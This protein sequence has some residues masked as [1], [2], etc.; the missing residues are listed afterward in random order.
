MQSAAEHLKKSGHPGQ[1]LFL[2]ALFNVV[3]AFA[4]TF[5]YKIRVKS[6][7]GIPAEGP[8][9]IL[10]K[11]WSLADVPL[12]KLAVTRDSG[13]H[14]WCVMKASLASGPFGGLMLK[15]GG[16]PINRDN[17]EKSK[18]DL[19]LARHVLHDG[20]MLCVFPEQ[21]TVPKKM[22]RG[23]SP[24]FR[25]IMGRPER[26]IGVV[27]IGFH[28]TKRRFRRTLV[29]IHIGEA[30]Y[31]TKHDD[32]ETFLHERMR[33]IARLSRL[34]YGFAPPLSRKERRAAGD[35]TAQNENAPA[36]ADA[37]ADALA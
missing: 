24:G 28:Y 17:P 20:A 16:I 12:G 26:P 9:I 13:R 22:G 31:F 8:V 4:Y 25:F 15:V 14:L 2:S 30:T 19:L 32:A 37:E 21:T 34:E 7:K 18:N 27:C 29:D 33:D 11:H 36:P 35:A 1:S 5:I 6:A 23:R 3:V 10:A